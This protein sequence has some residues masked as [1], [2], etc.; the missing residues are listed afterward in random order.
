MKQNAKNVDALWVEN[1][2]LLTFVLLGI[3]LFEPDFFIQKFR[4]F[5]MSIGVVM[6][7]PC[8]S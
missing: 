2:N 3:I 6:G 7:G 5:F 1:V 8:G 4:K